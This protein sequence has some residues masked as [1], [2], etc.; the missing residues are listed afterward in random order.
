MQRKLLVF[1]CDGVLTYEKSSWRLL[2]RYFGSLD[3]SYFAELY[4]R[5]LITYLDWMKIDIALMIHSHGKPI[6]K[7]DLEKV[8]SNIEIRN[9]A[10][11]VIREV[12]TRG[13]IPVVISSGVDQL[14]RKICSE[15]GIEIC[16]Y[17]ELIYVNDELI[18]GGIVNVPLKDKLRVIRD[19]AM[20]LGISLDDTIYIGDDEWDI[21]VFKSIPISIAIEPCGRACGYATY[22]IR[23]LREIL[24]LGLI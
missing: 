21:E 24:Y 13:H 8:F 3:N 11:E 5:D 2:H 1:D 16:Y 14:V 9:G 15:L 19:I 7:I 4:R 22:V 20:K 10:H 12:K 17:N 6:K 23:D 18:P